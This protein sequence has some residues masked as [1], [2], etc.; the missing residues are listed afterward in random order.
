MQLTRCLTPKENRDNMLE[1]QLFSSSV[2]VAR[3]TGLHDCVSVAY[4]VA[5]IGSDISDYVRDAGQGEGRVSGAT[6]FEITA[7]DWSD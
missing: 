1:K 3:V 5:S 7:C 2:R 6:S 4:S